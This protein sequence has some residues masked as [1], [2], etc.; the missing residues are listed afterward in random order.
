MC[1]YIP[2]FVTAVFVLYYNRL[3]SVIYE[4]SCCFQALKQ[5]L[6]LQVTH[7]GYKSTP[8]KQALKAHTVLQRFIEHVLELWKESL[9]G[10]WR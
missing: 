2:I 4:F 9:Q 8:C 10:P 3:V 6:H 1:E 7:M 5:W